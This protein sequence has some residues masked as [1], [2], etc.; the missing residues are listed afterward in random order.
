M[1]QV[2]NDNRISEQLMSQIIDPEIFN[3]MAL[4]KP[5]E[6]TSNSDAIE[7]GIIF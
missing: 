1:K 4:C 6:K 2:E 7:K 3:A 5:E